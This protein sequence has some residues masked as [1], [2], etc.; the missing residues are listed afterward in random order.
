MTV[1]MQNFGRN[2]MDVLIESLQI[3]S[4]AICNVWLANSFPALRVIC[5]T[6]TVEFKNKQS[7]RGHTRP[8]SPCR[9]SMF[10][11]FSTIWPE[12]NGQIAFNCSNAPIPMLAHNNLTNRLRFHPA[13]LWRAYECCTNSNAASTTHPPTRCMIEHLES[14]SSHRNFWQANPMRN[15][16]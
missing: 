9:T 13:L 12:S 2:A 6:L 3:S 5:L 14:R 1:Q 10:R 7:G 4:I 8:A 11:L 16:P 15:G